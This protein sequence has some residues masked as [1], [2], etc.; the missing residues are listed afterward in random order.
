M[1]GVAAPRLPQAEDG[2]DEEAE[3]KAK[4]E[5]EACVLAGGVIRVHLHE[6]QEVVADGER[7]A[8]ACNR[9]TR[10]IAECKGRCLIRN[11]HSNFGKDKNW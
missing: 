3:G 5:E 4:L 6:G 7:D 8:V 11:N 10:D 9:M 1:L 2:K